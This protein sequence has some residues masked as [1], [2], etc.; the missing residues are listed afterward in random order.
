LEALRLIHEHGM[1][2]ETSFILGFPDETPE[3]VKRTLELSRF[4]NPD[5]AH[6]L[7]LAPWPYA[8]MYR[9][10]KPYV[11]VRDYR[12]YNLIDPVIEPENMSL[13]DIDRAIIDCYQSFYMGKLR[14]L[15]TMKDGFKKRYLLHSMRL[16]MNSSFIVDKLG[17]AGKIPPQVEALMRKLQPEPVK[18]LT[19]DEERYVSLAKRSVFINR[20]LQEVF[21]MVADPKNWPSFINGLEG[22]SRADEGVFD[23]P[24]EFGWQYR[25]RGIRLSGRGEASE[26]IPFKRIVL[27]MESMMPIRKV[28]EFAP[29]GEGTALSVEVGYKNPGKVLS[30]LFNAVRRLL[31]VMETMSVLER[32]RSFCEEDITERR[33][34]AGNQ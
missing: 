11:K 34:R 29:E 17:S 10:L 3:S 24:G 28:I 4:Y 32:I 5:F 33:E 12:K 27:Q 23:R 1:I 6:Y 19:R 31:N 7:A 16:I 13:K 14:E 25:I 20:P 8:D 15:A 21:R 18:R 2:S 30:F 9:E 26:V 22:I